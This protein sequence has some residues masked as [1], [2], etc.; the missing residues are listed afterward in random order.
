MGEKRTA[1]LIHASLFTVTQLVVFV[2]PL[3]TATKA[4][5]PMRT[6]GGTDE[7]P[8]STT[9]RRSFM[10]TEKDLTFRGDWELSWH[11]RNHVRRKC[12]KCP[13][14]VLSEGHSECR[15]RNTL[16]MDREFVLPFAAAKHISET[17]QHVVLSRTGSG[18][19]GF[20]FFRIYKNNKKKRN[21]CG[22]FTKKCPPC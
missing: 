15:A 6:K 14:L 19:H 4:K 2:R 8:K 7:I 22:S 3:K 18:T 5:K 11:R 1:R 10:P 20:F 21:K 12:T 16:K 13:C 17:K 9:V